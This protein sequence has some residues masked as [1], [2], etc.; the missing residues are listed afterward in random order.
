MLQNLIKSS[1]LDFLFAMLAFMQGDLWKKQLITFFV[2]H[3]TESQK[4]L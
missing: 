3:F 2:K 1:I 4:I